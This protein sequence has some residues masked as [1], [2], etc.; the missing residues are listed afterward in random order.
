[1][2]TFV[3]IREKLQ[4]LFAKYDTYVISISKF[5]L[6]LISFSLI[7]SKMG[8]M[9]KLDSIVVILLLALFSSFLP[10]N[11]IVLLGSA[12]ILGHLYALSIPALIVGGG[13]IVILLLLYFGIAPQE[14]LALIFT[15]IAL[16]LHIPCAVPLV[17]GLL[18]TPL[19][20]LAIC[21]GT[22]AFYVLAVVAQNFGKIVTGNGGTA[23]DK[24]LALVGEIQKYLNAVIEEKE[25]ILMLIVMVAV[26]LIVYLIRRMA[27]KYAWTLAIIVGTI[28]FLTVGL[29]GS[30]M[31]GTG[32]MLTLLIGTLFSLL[33][34][35][36]IQFFM[37]HVDYTRTQN[38]QFED[39]EY[40]YYVKAVP[41][42]KKEREH[43][44]EF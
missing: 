25:M 33:L 43:N 30:L 44:G 36:I 15:M 1:M 10:V 26:L 38:V 3:E 9:D 19:A 21:T 16:V 28:T 23:T 20:A 22:I 29:A 4:E 32:S 6:A 14:S 18:A 17:F 13:I 27:I 42:I 12:L 41:K 31:L 8:Y 34:A 35:L 39:N 37:F 7:N 24:S 11:A 2:A 5:V 40:Y